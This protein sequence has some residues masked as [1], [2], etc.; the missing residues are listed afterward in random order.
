MEFLVGTCF[1]ELVKAGGGMGLGVA[2]RDRR[3]RGQRQ[4]GAARCLSGAGLP[5]R[6][7]AEP[8]VERAGPE[9]AQSVVA[10]VSHYEQ[11]ALGDGH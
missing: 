8:L 3:R 5:G 1:A 4:A 2:G 10:G 9:L 11:R 7:Q 6:G